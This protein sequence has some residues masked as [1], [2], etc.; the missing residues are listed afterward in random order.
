MRY[1]SDDLH[2]CTL[3]SV[4]VLLGHIPPV[5][6]VAWNLYCSIEQGQAV[7]LSGL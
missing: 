2:L 4:N 5:T 3:P 1:P 7:S 6:P